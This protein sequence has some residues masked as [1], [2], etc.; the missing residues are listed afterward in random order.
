[1]GSH[2]ENNMRHTRIDL[3]PHRIGRIFFCDPRNLVGRRLHIPEIVYG[4]RGIYQHNVGAVS[5]FS[6]VDVPATRGP[7]Y[8]SWSGCSAANHGSRDDDMFTNS[9]GKR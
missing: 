4:T 1:M 7:R 3:S 5:R 8:E 9:T 2:P 6:A